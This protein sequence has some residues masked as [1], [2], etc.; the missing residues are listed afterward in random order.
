MDT[1]V[2]LLV[3]EGYEKQ[4]PGKKVKIEEDWEVFLCLFR[5]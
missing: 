1:K 4:A 3:E 5:L 2:K